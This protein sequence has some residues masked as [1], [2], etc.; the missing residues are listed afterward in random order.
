ML[1]ESNYTAKGCEPHEHK[2]NTGS[3]DMSEN[4]ESGRVSIPLQR[5]LGAGLEMKE[6]KST[7]HYKPLETPTAYPLELNENLHICLWDEKGEY[8]WRTR[9]QTSYVQWMDTKLVPVLSTANVSCEVS[10]TKKVGT[11]ETV[12]C[13]LAVAEYTKR[14]GGVDQ[15]DRLRDCYSTSNDPDGNG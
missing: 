2:Q 4:T 7:K 10:R 8:K 12:P 13:P 15:F 6:P 11:R 1:I 9:R 3:T 5:E 14:M